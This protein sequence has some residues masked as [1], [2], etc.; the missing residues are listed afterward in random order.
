MRALPQKLKKATATRKGRIIA[1]SILIVLLASIGGAIANWNVYRKQIIRDKLVDTI[2]EKSQGL[3]ALHYDSLSLDEVAGD[4][5]VA[6]LELRYDSIKF[7]LLLKNEKAPPIL[8]NIT[9]PSISVSGVKTPRALLS[10]EIVGKKILISNPVINIL[11]TNAGKDSSNA[12][13]DKEIYE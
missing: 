13:P 9:I 11:Y 6:N 1:L 3:Y 5:S 4:L 8:V 10:K 7:D 2:H 12:V